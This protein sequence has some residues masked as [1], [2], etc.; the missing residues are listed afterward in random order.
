MGDFNIV[1]GRTDATWPHRHPPQPDRARQAHA[2]LADAHPRP[3]TTA[4][5]A[6][7]PAP[8]AAA[9]SPIPCSGSSWALSSST[10]TPGRSST[11]P[12]PTTPGSR[13]ASTSKARPGPPGP[14]SV[15]PRKATTSAASVSRAMPTRSSSTPGTNHRFGVA[16]KRRSHLHRQRRLTRDALRQRSLAPRSSHTELRGGLSNASHTHFR[17]IAHGR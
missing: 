2:Q 16:D 3:L 6:S 5:S 11:A 13:T 7:S 4:R 1:P 10:S 8:P 9:P 17:E 14:A 12:A 15:W